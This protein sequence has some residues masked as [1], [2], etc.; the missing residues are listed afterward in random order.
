MI[1]TVI[2]FHQSTAAWY[3]RVNK[4]VDRIFLALPSSKPFYQFFTQ[5]SKPLVI[6]FTGGNVFKFPTAAK[7][8]GL[9]LSL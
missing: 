4:S 5:P 1:T 3:L 9:F 7:A 2:L 8:T 6:S